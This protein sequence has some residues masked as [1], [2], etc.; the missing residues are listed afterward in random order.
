MSDRYV[1][2]T[3]AIIAYFYGESGHEAIADLLS[4][5][6][7]GDVDGLLTEANASEVFYLVARFEGTDDG[8]PTADSFRVADRDLRAL[9]RRGVTVTA[10]DWRLVGKVKSDGHI[11]LADAAAVALA[12]ERDA[13][14]VVGGD[15]DFDDLPLE[16]SCERFRDHGV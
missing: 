3:E 11:S 12:Y 8:T 9:E 10:P 7:A 13:T 15:D 14:L 16:V 6:F 4:A 5:V 1:F 2:D